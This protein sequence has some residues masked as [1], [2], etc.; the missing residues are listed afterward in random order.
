MSIS[1]F[2][3]GI[4]AA[5]SGTLDTE[6]L[7][8]HTRA[9]LVDTIASVYGSDRGVISVSEVHELLTTIYDILD[10]ATSKQ[11]GSTSHI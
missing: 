2:D 8:S 7:I 3:T 5:A 11:V 1:D 10:S 6:Q 4:G 9:T